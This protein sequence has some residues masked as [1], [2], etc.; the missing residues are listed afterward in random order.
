MNLVL[1]GLHAE[2]LK[3]R[4]TL[5]LRMCVI[6]PGL[7]VALMS[8]QL[9]FLDYSKRDISPPTEAWLNFAQGVVGMWSFLMLPLFVTLQASLLAGLEHQ[10]RQWKFLLAL[11]IPR[12]SYFVSKTLMLMIVLLLATVALILL[13]PLGGWLLMRVQP[14]SGIS[15]WPPLWEIAK[16]AL[17]MVPAAILMAVI[18]TWISLRWASFTVAVSVGMSATVAGFLIGQSERFGH[19]YPWSMPLWTMAGDARFLPSVLLTSVGL[20][21]LG[22]LIGA[23]AFARRDLEA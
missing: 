13:I 21:L 12:H 6:A 4:R 14:G 2:L 17:G 18:Q 15:G 10:S 16:P 19:W 3:L 8:L 23:W 20:G 7:V 1:R 5:A 9:M 11:P 22:L